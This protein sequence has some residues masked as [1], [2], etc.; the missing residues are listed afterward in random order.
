VISRNNRR[1]ERGEAPLDVE[2]E[3][4]RRLRELG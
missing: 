3:V 2:E 4:A 1:V